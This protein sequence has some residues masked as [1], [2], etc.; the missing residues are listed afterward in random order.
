M[1]LK[2]KD[3]VSQLK[4][5]IK[6]YGEDVAVSIVD[7]NGCHC[8]VGHVEDTFDSGDKDSICDDSFG[9]QPIISIISGGEF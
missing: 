6:V 9:G 1:I 2:A 3:L 4:S 7:E 8:C 5:L